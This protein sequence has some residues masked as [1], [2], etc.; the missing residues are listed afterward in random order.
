M[1]TKVNTDY[2]LWDTDDFLLYIDELFYQ[3]HK[4]IKNLNLNN[5][6]VGLE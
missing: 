5:S 4:F 6:A 2:V 1:G 3:I